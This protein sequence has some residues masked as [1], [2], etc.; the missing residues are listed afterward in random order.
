M[1]VRVCVSARESGVAVCHTREL[2]LKHPP[3]PFFFL[4]FARDMHKFTCLARHGDTGLQ[5]TTDAYALNRSHIH[6]HTPHPLTHAPALVCSDIL[7]G[8]RPLSGFTGLV[9]CGGFSYGDVLGAGE[10]YAKQQALDVNICVSIV[11][12]FVRAMDDAVCALT[13]ADVHVGCERGFGSLREYVDVGCVCVWIWIESLPLCG[14]AH[15]APDGHT[16]H[17]TKLNNTNTSR[18]AKSIL[19]HENAR[20]EFSRFFQRPDTFALGVCNGCQMMSALK[21]LIPGVY[22]TLCLCVC[23]CVRACVRGC[24]SVGIGWAHVRIL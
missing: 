18:W 10:G 8:K 17:F 1:C 5:R 22:C 16:A 24:A 12:C 2:H 9:A 6:T 14:G 23:V 7:S 21:E 4:L 11:S 13:D 3:S 15:P 20:S 19:Y